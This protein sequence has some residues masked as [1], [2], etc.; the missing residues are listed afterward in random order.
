M[1]PDV[2]GALRCMGPRVCLSMSG[3]IPCMRKAQWDGKKTAILRVRKPDLKSW[4]GQDSAELQFSPLYNGDHNHRLH[5]VAA[6]RLMRSLEL[7][8]ISC[9]C[10][11]VA[12]WVPLCTCARAAS[13]H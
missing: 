13:S 3:L 12:V 2:G 1:G 4:C 8:S 7:S 6:A 5:L 11:P 10:V 9:Q